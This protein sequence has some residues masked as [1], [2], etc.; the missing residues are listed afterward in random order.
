MNEC[1]CAIIES[2]QAYSKAIYVNL[3]TKFFVV[4]A[5]NIWRTEIKSYL[6]NEFIFTIHKKR[7]LI[8]FARY[9]M[10]GNVKKTKADLLDINLIIFIITV[11]LEVMR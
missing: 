5:K 9:E 2:F 6:Q 4:A 11:N 1:F 8:L 3:L 7:Q 10:W